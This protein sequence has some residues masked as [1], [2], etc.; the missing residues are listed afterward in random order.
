MQVCA[1]DDDEDRKRLKERLKGALDSD[2]RQLHAESMNAA[3]GWLEY[4]FGICRP[5]H[6]IG[7]L[8]SRFDKDLGY[9]SDMARFRV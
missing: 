6:R 8:G 3:E 7:K 4:V 5:D 2:R 9:D 1:G